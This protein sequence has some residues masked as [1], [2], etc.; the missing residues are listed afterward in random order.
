MPMI[1]NLPSKLPTENHMFG[2]VPIYTDVEEINSGNLLTVLSNACTT[3]ELN[4]SRIDYLWR[5]YKGEQPVLAR[6]KT[7]RPEINNKVVE[8]RANEIVSFKSGYL[9]GDPMQYVAHGAEDDLTEKIMRLNEFMSVEDKASKDLELADWMHICGTGYRIALP[10]PVKDDDNPFNLYVPDPRYTFVVYSS[11][12]GHRPLMGVQYMAKDDGTWYYSCWTDNMLY[13]VEN[14]RIVSQTPHLMQMVPVIEYPLNKPRIGAFEVVIDILNALNEVDSD[15]LDGVDQFIQSIIKF[16]NCDIDEKQFTAM[17]ELGAI[18]VQSIVQGMPADVSI[19]SQE[20]DQ[21]QTQ[22]L[23]DDLHQAYLDICGMPNRNGG[24]STSDTGSAVIMRDG[25]SAAEARAKD[26]ELMF[27]KAERQML[28]LVLRI[29]SAVSDVD[30][31]TTQIEM[32]FTRRNYSDLLT[33]SQVLT[34][35]LAQPRIHPEQ[36]FQSCGM[37]AD[38]EAAY[39][40]GD[41]FYQEYLKTQPELMED[42]DDEGHVRTRGQTQGQTQSAGRN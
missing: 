28:K 39:R 1:P 7:Y 34:T 3:H 8:N 27:K 26:T 38:P 9:F 41:Q 18:K 19:I 6:E 25:W 35:M 30:L 37:F 11:R 33:K 17:K 13:E 16:S 20:L 40:K 22:T 23:K 5:Y 31:K 24:S 42:D 12:L 21:S 2:R 15:R 4:S 32:A 29:L 36:A 14:D 10:N